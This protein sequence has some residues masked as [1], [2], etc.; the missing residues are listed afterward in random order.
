MTRVDF[1]ELKLGR[2]SPDQFLCWL[3][4]QAHQK[5]QGVLLL[6]Q[7]EHDSQRLDKALWTFDDVN[8]LPHGV[9]ESKQSLAGINLYHQ[10][11]T[12]EPYDILI[13]INSQ[14]PEHIGQFPRVIEL[15][16]EHNKAMA[17]EHFRYYKDRGYPITH[18]TV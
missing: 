1:Y 17:R 3:C 11:L 18:N 16:H 15:V 5:Q 6:T 7:S 2:F 12:H 14:I 8:F 9:N 10:T 4:L 13:N